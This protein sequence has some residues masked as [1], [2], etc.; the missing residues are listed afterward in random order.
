MSKALVELVE[1]G[2]WIAILGGLVGIAGFFLKLRTDFQ[3]TTDRQT[4]NIQHLI[5][6][7]TEHLRQEICHQTDT[8]KFQIQQFQSD[9]KDYR[10][11]IEEQDK[12]LQQLIT[13]VTI[14]KR[15]RGMK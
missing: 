15:L 1:I 11:K 5:D 2:L 13:D 3:N 4:M 6:D 7:K 12:K 9:L 14:L 8:V 10:A